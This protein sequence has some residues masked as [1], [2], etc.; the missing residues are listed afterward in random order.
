MTAASNL[1][2]PVTRDDIE[3]KLRELRGDVETTAQGAR[4]VALVVGVVAGVAVLGGIY[5]LG[6][7]KGRKQTTLVEIKRLS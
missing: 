4:N 5:L 7:R 3:S 2:R 1:D 6:R